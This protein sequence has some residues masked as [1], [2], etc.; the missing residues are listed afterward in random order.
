MVRPSGATGTNSVAMCVSCSYGN[1]NRTSLVQETIQV[2]SIEVLQVHKIGEKYPHKALQQASI[3]FHY[4]LL[5]NLPPV[6]VGI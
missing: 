2:V 3:C 6:M 1:T 5:H 4:L